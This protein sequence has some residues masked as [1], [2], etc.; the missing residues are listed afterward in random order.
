MKQLV[1]S[2]L[3][4]LLPMAAVAQTNPAAQ[5]ARQWRQQ[6]ERPIV[7]EFV[8]FL[9]I[10]NVT[11]DRA[12]IQRN[13]EFIVKMME[14]RGIAARL[15]S[16]EGANPIVFGEIRTPGAR[17]TIAFYAHYDGQPL[18]ETE[19]TTPPFTPTLR[20]QT[21]ERGGQVISLPPRGT[22]LDP[23]SR[24]YA[25]SAGDD[26]APIIAMMAAVDA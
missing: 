21:I 4:T 11:G 13:A 9:R 10:P 19:W 20:S 7:E 2:L 16:V 8:E 24:L 23:E 25:R 1:L 3:A 22:A 5:A 17:R 15:V 6:N 26:K 18:D 12:N 14:R